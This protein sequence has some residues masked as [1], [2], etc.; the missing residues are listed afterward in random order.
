[1]TFTLP[2]LPY[3][4]DALA[5]HVS[6]ETLEYHYGKHHNTYVTNL[7][8]LI[9]GTEFESMTLE[10]IIMKAKGGI[11]NNAAQVWNHTFYWHSMSPNGGGEPKGRLAEA[12]NKSFGSFAAFKEQFSQTAVTTF[13]SG[14]AWLVQDQS[15]ALKII[16]T[17][18]AGTPMTEGLNALLTCDVWEHAYYIDYRNRRPDY[19]EAFWS[20]VNWDFASSN[21]K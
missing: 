1:M 8:K 6:K 5:P 18:N 10:E 13:G 20:L 9:P 19:I 7:N 16:S 14:W 17:S 11:F 12:I 2:Q 21:L 3:A 15:G 4:L